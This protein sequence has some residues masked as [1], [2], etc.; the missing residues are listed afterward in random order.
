MRKTLAAE[1]WLDQT[2]EG[3]HACALTNRLFIFNFFYKEFMNLTK[4]S[5]WS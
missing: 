4:S 5:I 3:D 1:R 2:P